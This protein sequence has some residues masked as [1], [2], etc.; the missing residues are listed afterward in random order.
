MKTHYP[1]VTCDHEDDDCTAWSLNYHALLCDNW[2]ELMGDWHY[3]PTGRYGNQ[4]C[5]TH[6]AEAGQ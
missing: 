2:R 6:A 1:V 5:P 4:L 3:E